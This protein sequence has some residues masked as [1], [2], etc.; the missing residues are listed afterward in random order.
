MK[1]DEPSRHYVVEFL[2]WN[3]EWTRCHFQGRMLFTAAEARY[4][5]E[6]IDQP[7]VSPTRVRRTTSQERSREIAAKG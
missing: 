3:G 7:H 5:C 2:S 1:R 4:V 6:L